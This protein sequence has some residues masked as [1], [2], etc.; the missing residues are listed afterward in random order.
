MKRFALLSVTNK[1]SLRR[2]AKFL[3]IQ[4]Y[5]ILSLSETYQYLQPHIA[6]LHKIEDIKIILIHKIKE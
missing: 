3:E 2:F 1:Q 4:D 6:N 5:D